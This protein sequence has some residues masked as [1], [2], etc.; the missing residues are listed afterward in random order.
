MLEVLMSVV[1]D[2]AVIAQQ[3]EV[4]RWNAFDADVAWRLGRARRGRDGGDRNRRAGAVYGR[5]GGCDAGA[6]RLDSAEAEH[7]ATVRTQLLR[8]GTDART[9]RRDDGSTPWPDACGLRG[10]R[11]R[12]SGMGARR[13][14]R[15][16]R[17]C[18]G[19]A[20]AGRPQSGSRG[21]G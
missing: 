19:V 10:P 1:E 8:R 21:D 5:N 15:G 14:R 4:M 3:E 20:A 13:W 2:L 11:R 17:D 12:I 7:G 18:L 16:Q 9:R 6:G